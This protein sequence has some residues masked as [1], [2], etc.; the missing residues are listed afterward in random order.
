MTRE[1][2]QGGDD[3]RVTFGVALRI[4]MAEVEVPAMT[5]TEQQVAWALDIRAKMVETLEREIADARESIAEELADAAADGAL[6]H[7]ATA[8]VVRSYERDIEQRDAIIAA[9]ALYTDAEWW[10]NRRNMNPRG[11]I[12]ADIRAAGVR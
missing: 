4:L 9:A 7:P 8:N 12:Y 6:D 11:L 10:I 3:Y 2:V 5:G 1:A